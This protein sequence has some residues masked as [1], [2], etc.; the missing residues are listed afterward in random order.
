LRALSLL[1]LRRAELSIL[2]AGPRRTRS[3]NRRWRGVDRTTDVLSFPLYRSPAEFPEE[4]D[5]AIGDVVINP[6]MAA[7]QARL[8]GVSLKEEMRRLLV[9]GVLHLLGHDHEGS[10]YKRKKMEALERDLMGKL[11]AQEQPQ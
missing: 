3:L 1:G 11:E 8:S 7:E 5:F 9:H 2:L 10:A 6:S 4:N